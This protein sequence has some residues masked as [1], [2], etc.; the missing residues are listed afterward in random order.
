[1]FLQ[2][3]HTSLI[4]IVGTIITF[5]LIIIQAVIKG[6]N[7]VKK[8]KEYC[9]KNGIDYDYFLWSRSDKAAK[10]KARRI[11]KSTRNYVLHRDN[12]TCQNCG[13]TSN[14]HIDHIYPFSRGGSNSPHNLQVLC[15]KCNLSKSD[16]I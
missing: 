2:G 13:S 11:T 9:E 15:S 1:M 3:Q 4:E 14:L 6:E 5:I 8:D 10:A 7:I 12:Y 16:S